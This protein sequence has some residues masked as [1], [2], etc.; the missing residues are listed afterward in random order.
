MK[1]KGSAKKNIGGF[2]P[3]LHWDMILMSIAIIVIA[4][5]GYFGFVYITLNNH[6]QN[7]ASENAGND[8][9]ATKDEQALKKIVNMESVIARYRERDQAYHD[10]LKAMAGRAPAVVVPTT[11]TSTS[12][13]ATTTV[14]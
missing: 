6:I 4:I 14:R 12:S 9:A 11:T 2:A 10:L 3:E 5:A 13:V 8:T 7:I 1:K